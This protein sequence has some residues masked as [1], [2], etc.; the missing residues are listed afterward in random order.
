M[1]KLSLTKRKIIGLTVAALLALTCVGSLAFFSDRETVNANAEAA[2]ITVG[3]ETNWAD[4]TLLPGTKMDLPSTISNTGNRAMDV[5][6]T[7]ILTSD[8]ALASTGAA[9]FEIYAASDVEQVNG[10]WVPKASATPLATRSIS[11]DYKKITYA[12]PEF[13]LGIGSDQPENAINAQTT[14]AYVALFKAGAS[15]T[16]QNAHVTLKYVVEAKQHSG[17]VAWTTVQDKTITG[18]DGKFVPKAT[19]W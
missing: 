19:E 3:V 9:E 15:N 10:V 7:L 2:K 6:E 18:A 17:N 14:K 8:I 1:M 16:Y 5:K 4:T 12:L 11:S 13:T